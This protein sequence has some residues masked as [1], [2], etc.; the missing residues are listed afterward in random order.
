MPGGQ[1]VVVTTVAVGV[2]VSLEVGCVYGD[3]CSRMA[4]QLFSQLDGGDYGTC[5]VMPVPESVEE[6]EREHRTARKRT[7]RALSRGY[8]VTQFDRSDH[9]QEIY[10]IN[11]SKPSRQGRP[12]APAYRE[13]QTFS[14]LP[15]YPCERH[16]IR[17]W[18]VFTPA[19]KLAGYMTIYRCGDLVLV[20]QILGHGDLERDEIMFPL[21]AIGMA[22]EI[23]NPGVIVYN[24]WDSGTDGLRQFKRWL[25]FRELEVAWLP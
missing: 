20:S 23:G 17:T 10:E 19:R 13:R 2:G 18:G 6:W 14:P 15:D 3:E 1:G 7:M 24:R 9:A 22:F 4:G 21:F 5:A 16:A 25:G 12:M 8:F 11:T